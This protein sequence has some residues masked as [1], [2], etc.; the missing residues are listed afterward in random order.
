MDYNAEIPFHKAPS[1]GFWDAGADEAPKPK[2]FINKTRNDV[3]GTPHEVKEKKRLKEDREKME[4]LKKKDMPAAIMQMNQIRRDQPRTVRSKLVLPTPQVSDNELQELA[5]LGR[6]GIEQS[7]AAAGDGSG[8]TGT[9]L[10]DYSRTPQ[11]QAMR[12]PR[13][14]AEQ[15]TLLTEAQNIIALNQTTPVLAGGE[16][17]TL[18]DG[19]GSFD[20]MTPK[21]AALATP[22]RVLSTPFRGAS[23]MTPRA[24]DDVEAQAATP[25]RDGLNINRES[26]SALMTPR[27]RGE[28]ERQQLL[29]SELKHG[30]S[31]L[32]KPKG[33]YDIIAPEVEA[34][35]DTADARSALPAG[36]IEDQQDVDART[37]E[38][39]RADEDAEFRR[40]S[41][42]VQR[43]LPLPTAINRDV[44]RKSAAKTAEQASDEAIMVEILTMLSHDLG[45]DGGDYERFDDD[46]IAAARAMLAAEQEVVAAA[47]GVKDLPAR[48]ASSWAA[49][50]D[51]IVFVPSKGR[52]GR[53]SLHSKKDLVDAAEQE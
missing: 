50:R 33:D 16:N 41:Q 14:A 15:D 13:V 18:H 20:G 7:A 32:P 34:G 49:A 24:A 53:V 2:S 44:L 38:Q 6:S 36:F 27:T 25:L 39:R 46:A 42:A 1:A 11:V 48:H 47:A 19:G 51:D 40:Q 5:K 43:G 35:E 10:Q 26:N 4:A 3:E 28:Y 21:R 17:A 52:F 12:T 30:L 45:Q 9:L 22:N 31:S 37:D 23:G 29:K 8:A